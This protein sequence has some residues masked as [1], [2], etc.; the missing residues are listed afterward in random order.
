[1]FTIEQIFAAHDK[2]KSGADFPTY[3]REI[4]EL[5][6]IGFETR[7]ID[8]QT[9]YIGKDGYKITS[10]PQYENLTIHDVTDR[11]SFLSY[12]KMHQQA[13]TDY[14][15]FCQHCAAT[16]IEKWYADLDA[17]TCTYF[18]KHKNEILVEMIPSV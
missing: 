7:V 11:E 14:F 9:E 6:V 10:Q 5:G 13:A 15:T 2:V 16:G 17:M 1:M 12:L 3:I 8:S 4:K 18:D